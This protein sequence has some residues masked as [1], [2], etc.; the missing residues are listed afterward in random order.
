MQEEVTGIE[1]SYDDMSTSSNCF[2]FDLLNSF[3]P[4][5]IN[6]VVCS[7]Y[8]L[9]RGDRKG[10]GFVERTFYSFRGMYYAGYLS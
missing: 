3:G 2:I 7:E 1:R 5:S 9:D 10:G 8:L 6:S 4:M